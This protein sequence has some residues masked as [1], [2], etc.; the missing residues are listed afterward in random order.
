M[1]LFSL[2]KTSIMLEFLISPMSVI[3][4]KTNVRHSSMLVVNNANAYTNSGSNEEL[5][6][7]LDGCGSQHG[8]TNCGQPD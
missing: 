2:D 4:T 7:G 5:Q 3:G 1:Q 6:N 8:G